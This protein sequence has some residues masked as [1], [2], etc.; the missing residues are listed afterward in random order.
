[1][2]LFVLRK[3]RYIQLYK[4]PPLVDDVNKVVLL[5][6]PKSGC[7]SL[8]KWFLFHQNLLKEAL[9][10]HPFIHRYRQE[11]FQ[12]D[13]RQRTA[14]KAF[15]KSPKDYT[16]IKAV[17]NPLSRAV[18]SY[19]HVMKNDILY[20]EMSTFLKRNICE[21]GG[22]SFREFIRY[23][24]T[25]NIHKC[26]P[27]I[28]SQVHYLERNLNIHAD[29][30]FPLELSNQ[31]LNQLESTLNFEKRYDIDKLNNSFHHSRRN[32]DESFVGDKIFFHNKQT[33]FPLYEFFYDSELKDLTLNVYKEDAKRYS[34]FYPDVISSI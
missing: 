26:N 25:I 15:I 10:Y 28:N 23:L 6:T 31:W 8:I 27:H 2:K 14:L 13:C 7:T 17:R 9:D 12:K 22:F 29:Y 34:R 16:I 11:V 21:K 1:M 4:N 18:S 3:M 33:H 19:I 20:E 24:S 32:N 5:W 30:V